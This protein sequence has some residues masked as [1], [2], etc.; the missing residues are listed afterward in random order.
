M[1]GPEGMA[2]S[3]QPELPYPSTWVHLT[4]EQHQLRPSCGPISLSALP[5]GAHCQ[6]LTVFYWTRHASSIYIL[7]EQCFILFLCVSAGDEAVRSR[8]NLFLLFL[9]RCI[10]KGKEIKYFSNRKCECFN[11]LFKYAVERLYLSHGICMRL[12]LKFT[13]SN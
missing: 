8:R 11:A 6:T 10:N 12:Q 1:C 5:C 4:L 9:P 7:F 2:S 13:V 3:S